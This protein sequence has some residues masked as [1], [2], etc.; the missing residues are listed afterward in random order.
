MMESKALLAKRR[1]PSK[2][3]VKFSD[4]K[5]T[6]TTVS[7]SAESATQI[8]ATKHTVA[9]PQD[10][11]T[12]KT[13]PSPKVKTRRIMKEPNASMAIEHGNGEA[14]ANPHQDL[15]RVLQMV[16]TERHLTA[17][18]LYRQ[19]LSRICNEDQQ[20][21]KDEEYK[22]N[23]ELARKF[24][25]ENKKQ[26][27][28]LEKRAQ[29]FTRAK[30]NLAID[31]DWTKAQ[32]LFG[33]TT[34][35]RREAD[36]TLSIKMEGVLHG[37]PIFEQLAVLKEIDL[38]HTWAPFCASSKCVATLTKCDTI[39]HVMCGFPS[40]G[41]YRDACF[42]AVACDSMNEDGSIIIVAESVGQINPQSNQEPVALPEALSE[43][44]IDDD[45]DV[46]HDEKKRRI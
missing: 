21:K 40:F 15:I 2:L 18:E 16:S 6:T 39:G 13:L 32:T 34:Y 24:H 12:L 42:R 45:D 22:V 11:P 8:G 14:S 30:R 35:Y 3:N 4:D 23:L 25:K 1:S 27:E 9:A 29:L 37:V 28:N 36:K 38:Y 46:S 5:E 10:N 44:H 20:N 26:F 33:I 43:E 31:D 17:H 41:L 7:V 19:V